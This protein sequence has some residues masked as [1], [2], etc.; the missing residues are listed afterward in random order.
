MGR[1]GRQNGRPATVPHHA[2]G[3][4]SSHREPS[5]RDSHRI[6]EF[7]PLIF[8]PAGCGVELLSAVGRWLVDASS[9][10][11]QWTPAL[12]AQTIVVIH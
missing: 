8:L 9:P 2:A 10:T 4:E 1:A 5:H 12:E 7:V 3:R 11:Y 6:L